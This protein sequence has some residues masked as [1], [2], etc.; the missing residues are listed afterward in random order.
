MS[1]DNRRW[2]RKDSRRSN[3]QKVVKT[4]ED[5][6]ESKLGFGLF[7]EGE[8]RLG[9]LLTFASSSWEDPDT[10]KTYSCVDL[11]FVT[12]SPTLFP[13]STK[14]HLRETL[15]YSQN[16]IAFEASPVARKLQITSLR[17]S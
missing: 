5:E 14:L 2:D 12:Q 15:I 1:G 11:Y 3:T 17:V 8:T 13:A 10:G 16:E 7:S 9:W 6:L 4:A